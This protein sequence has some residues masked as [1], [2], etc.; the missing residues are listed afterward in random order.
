MEVSGHRRAQDV[1]WSPRLGRAE[2]EAV[3]AVVVDAIEA[4]ETSGPQSGAT[5]QQQPNVCFRILYSK[6]RISSRKANN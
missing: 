6:S 5:K 3:M 1:P 2:V 4:G